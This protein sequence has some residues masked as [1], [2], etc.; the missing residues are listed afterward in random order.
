MGITEMSILVLPLCLLWWQTPMRLLQLML[1]T[2]VF[3][4]SAVLVLGGQG[5]Q[6]GLMPAAVFLGFVALQILLGARYPGSRQVWQMIRPFVLV[7]IWAVLSSIV[8]PRLLQGQVLVWPQKSEPPFAITPLAPSSGNLS[9]DMYLIVDCCVVVSA[10]LFLTKASLSLTTL[11]NV[12]LVSGLV[13]AGLAFWQLGNKLA[14]LPYP[15]DLLYSNPGWAILTSQQVGLVPRINGPFSEPS[16]LSS[17][18]GTIVCACIWTRLQGHK[19]LKMRLLLLVGLLV[20]LLTTSTTGFGVLA[21]VGCGIPIYALSRGDTRLLSAA[22]NIGIVLFVTGGLI[23]FTIDLVEPSILNN[24]QDVIEGTLNKQESS[25]YQERTTADVDSLTAFEDSFGLGTG[26]GS[27]RS[28]SLI[29]GLLATLGLPGV[30]GL[31]WFA[32]TLGKH[33]RNARRCAPSQEALFIIDA[34]CGA[35]AGFLV[36]GI[37]SGPTISSLTFYFLLA[38]LVACVAKIEM[39]APVRTASQQEFQPL[40]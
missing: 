14:G 3:D 22:L 20:M 9:Q 30:G 25:S 35:L 4:A 16:S 11:L 19:L 26:W 7:V 29:P 37:L 32:V 39:R 23:L 36:A 5:V 27:N 38:L 6:T 12:Y 21:I 34:C 13:A 40:S 15:S 17:Y 2:A 24:M 33:V 28:S 8:M 10:S 31:I 18:M 1:I